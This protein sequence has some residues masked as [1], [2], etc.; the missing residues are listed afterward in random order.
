LSDIWQACKG[1]EQIRPLKRVVVRV[2]E[3]QEQVATTRLVD[4]SEEQSQLEGLLEKTKPPMPRHAERYDYLIWTPFRYPPLPHG[5]RFGGR[6]E[7]GLF[8]GALSLDAALAECAYYRLVF[9]SGM[10]S[11]LPVERMTTEHAS[12]QARVDAANGVALEGEPF[13]PHAVRISDPTRYEASQSL[14]RAMRD[15]GVEAFTY[16]SARHADGIN[17]GVFE[18]PAIKSRKPEHMRH[19]LCTTMAETVSFIRL[20]GR[21][22]APYTFQRAQ[23]LVNDVLPRPAL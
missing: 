13:I 10:A 9:L 12:F 19:W 21:D 16:L 2:V 14:G 3:S 8:Y 22:E 17:A 6:A 20:H 5:S 1:W 7:R 18:L 4:T 15:A 23:F 11:P